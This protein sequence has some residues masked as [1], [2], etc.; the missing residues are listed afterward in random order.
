MKTAKSAKAARKSTAKPGKPGKGSKAAPKKAAVK[1][2][3][4]RTATVR[5]LG[6]L[7]A[8][9]QV[10]SA[11]ATPMTSQEMIAAMAEQKL[12][13]SPNGKTPA[14][15]LYAA[16][17]REIANKGDDARFTKTERGKFAARPA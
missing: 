10:L 2:S 15:T 12:W 8:A 7:S 9:H 6:V 5:K 4:K 1:E 11:S 13:S 17:I 14:Q 3:A 16:I